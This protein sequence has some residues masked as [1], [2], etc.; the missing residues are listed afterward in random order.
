MSKKVLPMICIIFL[1]GCA[2]TQ[3]ISIEDRTRTYN[4]SYKKVF[5]A[6][7]KAFNEAGFG[8][9]QADTDMGIITT[10]YK[11]G[12]DLQAMFWGDER[13]KLNAVISPNDAGTKVNLTVTLEKKEGISGWRSSS[14]TEER[15]KEIY[16][17]YFQ[18][19]KENIY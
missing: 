18:M 19:I 12:S 13:T 10:G 15:A 7:M 14:M 11:H 8:I 5:Q 9:E 2:T 1:L 17:K 6:T 3:S 16:T 4:A